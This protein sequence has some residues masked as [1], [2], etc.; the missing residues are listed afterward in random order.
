MEAR[1]LQS[2]LERALGKRCFL[3]SDDLR[4]LSQLCRHVRQSEVLVLIQSKSVLT[5]PYCLLELLTAMDAGVPI[6]SV[7]L[8]K[9]AFPYDYA[10]AASFLN[11][12]DTA[13]AHANPDADALLVEHGHDLV[14]AA[15]K[16]SSRL[17]KVISVHL[18]TCASRNILNATVQDLVAAMRH[19][20]PL[21]LP[22][23]FE[24]WVK[25]RDRRGRAST[26]WPTEHGQPFGTATAAPAPP[27]VPLASSS[28][29]RRANAATRVKALPPPRECHVIHL[30]SDLP[31]HVRGRSAGDV[32][33]EA[34]GDRAPTSR[35]RVVVVNGG[36]RLGPDCP[37]EPCCSFTIPILLM[38]RE[39]GVA[40]TEVPMQLSSA[41]R[42]PERIAVSAACL[43]ATARPCCMPCCMT[44]CCIRPTRPTARCIAVSPCRWSST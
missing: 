3:D 29:G 7:F 10:A 19:A 27:L 12:L 6:V 40:F 28:A 26:V 14:Q 5:R 25:M 43:P 30:L 20:V 23:T 17:P 13:L 8:E 22:V 31:E 39:M 37:V 42:R 18:D 33:A 1:F 21:P 41:S 15:Y 24:E 16:L 32:G 9:H 34:T 44:C 35:H 38:L 2:E 4:D 11:G 36:M